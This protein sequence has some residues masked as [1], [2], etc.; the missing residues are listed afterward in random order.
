M[1]TDFANESA[2]QGLTIPRHSRAGGN[3]V[4]ELC[5]QEQ[6]SELDPRLRGDDEW[7]E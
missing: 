1:H 7:N 4:R 5:W 3:P 2:M 6:S